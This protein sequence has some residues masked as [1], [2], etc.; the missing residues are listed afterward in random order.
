M[1]LNVDCS[2]ITI[3]IIIQ[4]KMANAC[5]CCSLHKFTQQNDLTISNKNNN[6]NTN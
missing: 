5:E 3:I 1:S 2:I 6:Y 4:E